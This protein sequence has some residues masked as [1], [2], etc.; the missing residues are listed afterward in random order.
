MGTSDKEG[1]ETFPKGYDSAQIA[2]DAISLKGAKEHSITGNPNSL[3]LLVGHLEET[4]SHNVL[5]SEESEALIEN[6]GE[7]T[8]EESNV[9]S[10][11]MQPKPMYLA[12]QKAKEESSEHK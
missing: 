9:M 5:T 10:I 6:L 1:V 4:S 8:Q 2:A 11:E 12:Q 7:K 3:P